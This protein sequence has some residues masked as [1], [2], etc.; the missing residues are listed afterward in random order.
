[1]EFVKGIT[2]GRGADVVFNTTA[3]PSVVPQAIAM[4]G[5]GGRMIQYSSMHPDA[6]TPVSPQ[7]LHRSEI[8]LTGS[9]SPDGHDFFTANRLLS[10]GI[11]D[12]KPLIDH[13][14]PF[15]QAQ[16]AFEA[17]IVPGT[18]RVIITD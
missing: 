1:M 10:G 7:L 6:P 18:F 9:I 4:V 16:A 3:I 12:C 11:I 13:T 15:E 2:D 5:K 8:I 17:A 14:V